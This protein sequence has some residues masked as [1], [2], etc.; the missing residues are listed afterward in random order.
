MFNFLEVFSLISVKAAAPSFKPE[1]LPAVTV[2]SFLKTG[3]SKLIFSSVEPCLGNS[4]LLKS[5]VSFFCL[6]RHLRF[7]FQTY[8]FWA[9]SALFCDNVANSS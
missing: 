2:P 5:T 6:Q 8:F 4:S 9:S 3:L 7:H 1:A